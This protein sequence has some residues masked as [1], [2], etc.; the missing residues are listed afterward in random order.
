MAGRSNVGKSSLLNA[1][2]GK[3][4]GA[5]GTLGVAQVKNLPGVTRAVNFYASGGDGPTLVDL[6]GYGFAVAQDEAVA[7]WQATM[8]AYL[9]KRAEEGRNIRAL[10]VVDARQSLKALDRDFALWLDRE[11]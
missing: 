1:L 11:A 2:I 9:A 7:Q 6:P 4:S 5:S 8:R 3:V 10:V